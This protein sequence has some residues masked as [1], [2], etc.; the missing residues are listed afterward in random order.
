MLNIKVRSQK[1]ISANSKMYAM[2]GTQF[3]HSHKSVFAL[4]F[5]SFSTTRTQKANFSFDFVLDLLYLF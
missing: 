2:L 5:P 3:R 1:P 4:Q